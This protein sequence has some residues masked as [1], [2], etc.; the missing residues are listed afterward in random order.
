MFPD[1]GQKSAGHP[2]KMLVDYALNRRTSMKILLTIDGVSFYTTPVQIKK[3]VGQTAS[4]N[5]AARDLYQEL[6]ENR[7]SP[8][9]LGKTVGCGGTNYHGH[10]AQIFLVGA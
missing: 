9:I 2:G 5:A 7:K 8:G 3:G 6:K 10:Q 1:W 4:V